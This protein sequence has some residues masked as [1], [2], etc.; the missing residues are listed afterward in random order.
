MMMK[1]PRAS[2]ISYVV[3]ALTFVGVTGI[4]PAAAQTPEPKTVADFFLLVPDNYME[5]YD[6]SFREELLA[7]KRR[8]AVVDTANGFISYEASDNPMGFEFAIFRK[9]NGGY[10]VAYSNSISDNFDWEIMDGYT[11]YLLS[12]DGGNWRDVKESL[13]P[14]PFNKKLTYRL[15][16]RGTSIEVS[17]E[18]G[19]SLY[20]MA[21]RNDRFEIERRSGK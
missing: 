3:C 5:G 18:K 6:R 20:T 13:L 21:W 7:G 9:S 10:I 19:R 16:R 14:K 17:D 2:Q 12:Y 8:G 4:R 15:P 11:L 1:Y